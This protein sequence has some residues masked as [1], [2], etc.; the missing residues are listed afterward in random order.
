MQRFASLLEV[1]LRRMGVAVEVIRPR[2]V[3]GRLKPGATGIGK[4]LGYLDKF[5][6]FPF[7]LRR[8]ASRMGGDCLVHI[9]DHSNAFYT[10][11]LRGTPHLV[12]CNDLLAVRSALGEFA[13]N[14]TRLTGRR[15]QQ[16]ILGGLREARRIACISEATKTDLLRALGDERRC[17]DVVYMG[18]DSSWS[19]MPR[20]E[21]ERCLRK[22]DGVEAPFILHVGGT[23]WYKNRAGVLAIHEALGAERVRVKLVIAGPRDGVEA[24]VVY[25]GR[26]DD[27]TLR[28]LYSSAELLLFPS[29][30]E[31]YGWPIVEAQACGCRV[32]TTQKPPMTE[33]GGDAAFYLPPYDAGTDRREWAAAATQLIRSALEQDDGARSETVARGLKNAARFSAEIMAQRYV[34]IYKGLL[35]KA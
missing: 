20:G 31:G 29:L 10:R 30:E 21:A 14:P 24:D 9:C 2:P 5:F 32:A 11:W 12:T 4:W 35:Y 27:E 16:M 15:L 34:E 26:V 19:P 1:E 7:E 28:A 25:A 33:A 8:A 6:I 13:V 22:I 17:V 3:F 18:V 23:Q